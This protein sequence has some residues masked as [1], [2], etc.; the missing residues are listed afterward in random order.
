MPYVPIAQGDAGSLATLGQYQVNFEEESRGCLRLELSSPV[1]IDIVDWLDKR[2]ED[3]GVPASKVRVSGNSLFIYF[4][5]EIAPL[6]LIAAAI[7]ASI[8]LLAVVIAW[9]LYKLS[10]TAVIGISVGLILAI[11]A[12]VVAIAILGSLVIGSVRIGR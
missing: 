7:T 6:V 5:T 11:I 12:A 2:L 8:I 10:P 1:A 3:V 9:K 4:K